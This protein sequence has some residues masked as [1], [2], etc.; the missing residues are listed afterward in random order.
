MELFGI[1]PFVQNQLYKLVSSGLC[2]NV[3]GQI[4]TS[5]VS[6]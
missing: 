1:D 5:L 3:P 4:M 2:S 6:V